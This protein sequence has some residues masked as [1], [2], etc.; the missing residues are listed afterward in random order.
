M[1]KAS[2]SLTFVLIFAAIFYTFYTSKSHDISNLE[3]PDQ[4]FSTLRA[5]EHVKNI[6]KEPH[7]LGS[8]AHEDT[9]EYIFNELKKMGLTPEIHKG[10]SVSKTGRVTYPQNIIAKIKGSNTT[11]SLLVMSHYDSS[12]HSSYGASDAGS[13]VA[14]ILEGIRAYLATSKTPKNDIIICITDGE[15][16]GLNGADFFVKTHPW[17]K[18]VGLVLNFEARGS[19]GNSYM[20]LETNSKNAKMIDEFA[21]ANVAYPTTN[22][23]AYSIYK[24]LPNDTDLTV[25]REQADIDGFNFAFID[26]HFDYHTANDIWQN[27]DLETLQ[28]QGNY[29]MPLLFHFSQAD[30]NN[31]KSD[32]DYIYF[33]TP[34]IS[35]IKY[36]F[37]WISILLIAAGLLFIGA[38]FFGKIKH[39]LNFKE[40]VK[41]IGVF[42]MTLVIVGILTFGLWKL[43]QVIYPHYKEIQ[44]GF[45]YNG[46]L[47]I[48][49]FV[50]LAIA[51]CFKVYAKFTKNE[52]IENLFIGPIL[53]WLI[54]AILSAVYLKGASYFIF[55]VFFGLFSLYVLIQ[56]KKPKPLLMVIF[57]LPTIF[58]VSP[59]IASFPVALGLKILFVSAILTVLVF[60]ALLS[61]F[62]F[63]KRKNMLGNTGIIITVLIL[64]IAHFKSGF[65]E[66]RQKPNSL[67]Y[68]LDTDQNKAIWATYDK[69]LDSWTKN[70]INPEEDIAESYNNSDSK[71]TSKKA[72]SFTLQS[73]YGKMFKYANQA[74]I[75]NINPPKVD[76]NYD[77][78]IGN[79]RHIDLCIT[80]LRDVQRIDLYTETLFNFKNL[81]ANGISTKDFIHKDG[82]TYNAFTKR[83]SQNLTTHLLSN[84]EPL[85]LQMQFHKD[86][87]PKFLMYESSYDLLKSK[88]FS[89][90]KREK[91]MM[92][93]PFIVNDA[94]ITKKSFAIEKYIEKKKIDTLTTV[95][96]NTAI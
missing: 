44:H 96:N 33:N 71:S 8:P 36:P 51:I 45:T 92:P 83:W 75:K 87:L 50:V 76:I 85:E 23:L 47:Y 24:M 21:K 90:P 27:L 5:L 49:A 31:L 67:V 72:F 6:A 43:L 10:T 53:I 82:K 9:K 63:Y 77:T 69:V 68:I 86:S 7:Y 22:S 15:E 1:Q 17:V 26:D 52:N 91:D 73:K 62:G 80:P 19:G 16:L 12:P 29:L 4:E 25:F 60:G 93:K 28:H 14:T 18:E 78:I 38:L 74:P 39:K 61:I 40:V 34:V 64:V 30:L 95:E 56:Q 88:Y 20:L 13:G 41:G 11:K 79:Y 94:I 3:T 2:S 48:T 81:K 55:V 84:N 57:A 59:F 58:I 89:I 66:E 65:T 37:S 70:Y 54:I 35:L 32:E 46:Y 42:V